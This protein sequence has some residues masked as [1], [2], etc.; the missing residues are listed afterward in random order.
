MSKVKN[1][2]GEEKN[3]TFVRNLINICG[4]I[5]KINNSREKWLL[6]MFFGNEIAISLP[7][8]HRY[9]INANLVEKL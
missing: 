6:F 8:N 7:S 4:F 9:I 2:N 1:V 3:G 5:K